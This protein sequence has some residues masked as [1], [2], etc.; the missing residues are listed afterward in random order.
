MET[1]MYEK[2]KEKILKMLDRH[3]EIDKNVNS[4]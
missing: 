4:L 2:Q 3:Y 1:K